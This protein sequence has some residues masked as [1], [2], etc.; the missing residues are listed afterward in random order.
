VEVLQKILKNAFARLETQQFLL[1]QSI[2]QCLWTLQEWTRPL[3][4]QE[5]RRLQHLGESKRGNTIDLTQKSS[6]FETEAKK[7]VKQMTFKKITST[8][9]TVSAK[10][11]SSSGNVTAQSASESMR[12]PTS[13]INSKNTT[14]ITPNSSMRKS[15]ALMSDTSSSFDD[16]NH[17]RKSNSNKSGKHTPKRSNV[18][19]CL[20]YKNCL[21][22]DH[23]FIDAYHKFLSNEI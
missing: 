3:D 5:E 2:L 21:T 8:N 13:Q 7:K 16:D 9:T 22:N 12:T 18:Q 15:R 20:F 1:L 14:N 6:E 19:C 4:Y 11:A 23:T 17:S 10:V